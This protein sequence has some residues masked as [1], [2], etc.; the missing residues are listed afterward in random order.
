MEL[1]KEERVIKKDFE[2]SNEKLIYQLLITKW[3]CNEYKELSK[4]MNFIIRVFNKKFATTDLPLK[5][6]R[7]YEIIKQWQRLGLIKRTDI[8]TKLHKYEFMPTL[9]AKAIEKQLISKH[10]KQIMLKMLDEIIEV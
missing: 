2:K 9:F 8:G 4:H 7:S 5:S 6:S 10:E 1:S 3:L